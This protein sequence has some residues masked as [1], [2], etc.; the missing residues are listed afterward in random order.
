MQ[1]HVT[2]CSIK[3][4]Y[5]RATSLKRNNLNFEHKETDVDACSVVMLL[6]QRLAIMEMLTVNMFCSSL[7]EESGSSHL[8][9]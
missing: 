8:R 9:I 1:L 7:C 3:L 2:Y 4:G 6:R 5:H